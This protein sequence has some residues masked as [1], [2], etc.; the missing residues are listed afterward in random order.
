[1]ALPERDVLRNLWKGDIMR[2]KLSLGAVFLLLLTVATIVVASASATHDGDGTDE[3]A[4]V[5]QSV[6]ESLID[7]APE[8][9]VSQGD[10][11]VFSDDLFRDGKQVGWS[12][13]VCTLVRVGPGD[14][15]SAQCVVTLSLEEGQ[16]TAQG[17]SSFTATEVPPFTIAITGGT[18][19]YSRAHGELTLESVSATEEHYTVDLE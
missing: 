1:L 8:G 15:L 12:G 19:A 9:E 13:G 17:L 10:Q 5:G 7:L 14:A 16:I 2:R 3:F 6:Q 18:E 4:L 11:F